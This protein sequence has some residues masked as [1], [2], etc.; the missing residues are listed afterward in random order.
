[1]NILIKYPEKKKFKYFYLLTEKSTKLIEKN[2]YTFFV[3]TKLNKQQ[4]KYILEELYEINIISINTY[5][6]PKKR[7]R[8][9]Q[10]EGYKTNY[11]KAIIKIPASQS[12][13]ILPK[14]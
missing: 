3:H 8:F 5:N 11:K 2:Q 6:P 9:S 12:I 13:Q 4:I 1:M 14:N 10:F 7:K